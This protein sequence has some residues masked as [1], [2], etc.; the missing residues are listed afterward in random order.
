MTCIAYG[1]VGSNVSEN[2]SSCTR[3]SE[4]A[5]AEQSYEESVLANQ[6]GC[7]LEGQSLTRNSPVFRIWL[8]S[9]RTSAWGALPSLKI[10]LPSIVFEMSTRRWARVPPKLE[11]L[12]PD[13]QVLSL[14]DLKH[15]HTVFGISKVGQKI[16]ILVE[17]LMRTQ[18]VLHI[19]WIVY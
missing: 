4:W 19:L 12:P 16:A 2:L 10:D 13:H 8:Q 14:Q 18:T 7:C 9:R 11:P 6:A 15:S 1:P 5:W 3:S 17:C